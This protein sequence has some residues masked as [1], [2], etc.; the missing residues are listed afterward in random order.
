MNEAE[1]EIVDEAGYCK[2]IKMKDRSME[3]FNK[4]S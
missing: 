1:A 3:L 4:L 2:L